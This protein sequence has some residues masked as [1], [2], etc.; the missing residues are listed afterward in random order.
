MGRENTYFHLCHF[1]ITFIQGLTVTICSV[2]VS[3]IKNTHCNQQISVQLWEFL[4]TRPNQLKALSVQCFVAREE[5]MPMNLCPLFLSL[6]F[7]LCH[8]IQNIW[9][10]SCLRKAFLSSP[11]SFTCLP[12]CF[13]MS[14]SFWN[15]YPS[16]L[17]LGK[18]FFNVVICKAPLSEVLCISQ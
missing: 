7:K 15:H 8:L 16:D 5:I 11:R 18:I 3:R 9:L 6:Y 13:L 2:L 12:D 10:S 14:P 1:K 17:V 4:S